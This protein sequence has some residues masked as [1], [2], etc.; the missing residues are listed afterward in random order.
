MPVT[1]SHRYINCIPN[2]SLPIFSVRNY[3]HAYV[4]IYIYIYSKFILS[5]K[6]NPR[7]PDVLNI[8]NK[9][10]HLISNT[11]SLKNVLPAN[12][13]MVSFKREGEILI[14]SNVT[15]LRIVNWAISDVLS[16]VTLVTILCW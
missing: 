11:P 10:I 5:T 4:H 9:H 3:I 7:G 15:L 1:F 16:V 13:I 8:I 6:Y 14:T 12:S 2:E